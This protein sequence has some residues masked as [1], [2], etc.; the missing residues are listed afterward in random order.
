VAI[1][2]IWWQADI[3]RDHLCSKTAPARDTICAQKLLQP[4]MFRLSHGIVYVLPVRPIQARNS[5]MQKNQNHHRHSHSTIVRPTLLS[6]PETLGN[7]MDGRIWCR[8]ISVVNVADAVMLSPFYRAVPALNKSQE[9]CDS[10]N[11]KN[12]MCAEKQ[13]AGQY[14][15][16]HGTKLKI[17]E[18]K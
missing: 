3:S 18:N 2:Q 9:A 5:K 6:V 8:C 12:S 1:N 16:P 13:M 17:N 7:G 11:M 4:E 15:L 10:Y 14:S